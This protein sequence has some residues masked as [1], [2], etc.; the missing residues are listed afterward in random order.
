MTAQDINDQTSREY[1]EN[2]NRAIEA[3]D[4]MD[5]ACATLLVQLGRIVAELLNRRDWNTIAEMELVCR[6][7]FI[8]AKQVKDET[9][10]IIQ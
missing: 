2:L 5:R 10:D 3:M 7:L 4:P 9:I 6:D 8:Q 1:L